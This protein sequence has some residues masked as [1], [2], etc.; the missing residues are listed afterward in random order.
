MQ[1]ILVLAQPV[2]LIR[3]E[4]TIQSK[5]SIHGNLSYHCIIATRTL[6]A[7]IEDKVSS[8][9]RRSQVGTE[10]S[11]GGIEGGAGGAATGGKRKRG[12]EGK[13]R[14]RELGGE[15]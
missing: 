1:L 9:K 4:K 5:P 15:W 2:C 14:R 8:K 13:E 12:M 7:F 3:R 6:A 10:R 11:T